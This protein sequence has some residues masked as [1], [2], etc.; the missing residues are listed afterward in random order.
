MDRVSEAGRAGESFSRRQPHESG[1]EARAASAA[2][3]TDVVGITFGTQHFGQVESAWRRAQQPFAGAL[4]AR[5]S[6]G[7]K[8]APPRTDATISK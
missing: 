8:R 6:A 3:A 5:T 7:A 1:A 4:S 2:V